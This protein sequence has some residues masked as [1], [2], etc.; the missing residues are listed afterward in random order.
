MPVGYAYSNLRIDRYTSV[1]SVNCNLVVNESF[2]SRD[3][4]TISFQG[5]IMRQKILNSFITERLQ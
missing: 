4:E 3:K 2:I 1:L 5:T